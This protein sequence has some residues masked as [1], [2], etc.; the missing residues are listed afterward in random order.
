MTTRSGGDDDAHAPLS[1]TDIADL[2]RSVVQLVEVDGAAITVMSGTTRELVYATDAVSQYLDELQFTTGQ[3]P[4][5]DAF[6]RG[7]TV[8]VADLDSEA[9]E[10]W[11]GFAADASDGGAAAL[12]AFPLRGG[13]TVFGVLELYRASVGELSDE[14]AAVAQLTAD[15][16]AISLLEAFAPGLGAGQSLGDASDD[17]PLGDHRTRPY[18]NLAVGMITV[19]MRVSPTEALARLRAAAYSARRP[20]DDIAREVVERKVRFSTDDT[21]SDS[22]TKGQPS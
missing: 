14:F 13:N 16:A 8:F 19:Q 10:H 1:I 11:P 15:A 3:G 20:V 9:E 22:T 18:V 21:A 5:V 7:R 6:H 4:C 17:S 2:C 12:F